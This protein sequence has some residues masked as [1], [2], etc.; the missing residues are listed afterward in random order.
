[1]NESAPVEVRDVTHLYCTDKN[2]E[3]GK[4]CQ[5]F[6]AGLEC[7]EICSCGSECNNPFNRKSEE[8]SVENNEGEGEKNN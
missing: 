2:C 8:I 4:N 3:G 1:M 7:I 5:C 6:H